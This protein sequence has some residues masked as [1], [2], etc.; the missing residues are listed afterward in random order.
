MCSRAVVADFVPSK[1]LGIRKPSVKGAPMRAR[2]SWVLGQNGSLD[3][4]DVSVKQKA[5]RD[6]VDLSNRKRP[7]F[8][9]FSSRRPHS[10][11]LDPTFEVQ[12]L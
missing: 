3:W 5:D 9:R 8:N 7:A 2:K 4:L 6:A 1:T 10:E 11:S 12:Q